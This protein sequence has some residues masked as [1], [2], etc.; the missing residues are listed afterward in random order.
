[1]KKKF[2]GY[3][4]S[5]LRINGGRT[6][7]VIKVTQ[8]NFQAEVL[9]SQVPVI[10]DFWAEWCGPCRMLGP[11]VEEAAEELGDQVKVGKVN[12]DEELDL[13]QKFRIMSVPT[14][15]VFKNGEVANQSI[16]V[17]SKEEIK[18]LL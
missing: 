8:D 15:L 3:N 16:G 17:I 11:I 13:T 14:L 7:A 4:K 5:K 1:L 6:M 12:I 9:E 18:A 10:V 2:T